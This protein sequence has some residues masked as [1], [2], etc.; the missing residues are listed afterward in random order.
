MPFILHYIYTAE[1][2]NKITDK[3]VKDVMKAA[4]WLELHDLRK[5]CLAF[6]E[7]RLN[8][9]TVIPV[10]IEAYVLGNEK[11]KVKSMRYIQQEN[12]DLVKSAQWNLFKEENPKLALELYER[13]IEE[14]SGGHVNNNNT[15]SPGKLP[16]AVKLS[17]HS[18]AHAKLKTNGSYNGST[19]SN[20]YDVAA[21]AIPNNYHNENHQHSPGLNKK[22]NR[23]SFEKVNK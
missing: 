7:T 21:V 16:P 12:I 1:T 17:A 15:Q 10:L 5:C 23:A 9:H 18:H 3:N 22:S 11:L 20:Y 6:M 14:T 4:D 19:M 13:Y 2:D 8:R